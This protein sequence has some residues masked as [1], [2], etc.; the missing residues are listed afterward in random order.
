MVMF[1]PYHVPSI[2]V[3]LKIETRRTWKRHMVKIG[4]DYRIKTKML[5]KEYYGRIRVLDLFQ[6][7]LGDMTPQNAW[8]EGGYTLDEF[9]DIWIKI[10]GSWDN[11]I[12]VWVIR[13]KFVGYGDAVIPAE[14]IF[15]WWKEM[16]DQGLICGCGDVFT[17]LS[18]REKGICRRCQI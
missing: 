12:I 9:K 14:V 3:G 8:N 4:G 10:N 1:K 15:D 17:S 13:F 11:E 6:E 2:F 18:E 16:D 5:S 7:R